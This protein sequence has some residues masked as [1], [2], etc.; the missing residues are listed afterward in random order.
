[1]QPLRKTIRRSGKAVV[2]LILA[3]LLFVIAGCSHFHAA[4]APG[5]RHPARWLPP[6]TLMLLQ[7]GDAEDLREQWGQTPVAR[8]WK[9]PVAAYWVETS[10]LPALQKLYDK[11]GFGNLHAWL[12][13][14]SGSM[15][16]AVEGRRDDRIRTDAFLDQAGLAFYLAAD[17]GNKAPE[18]RQWMD[19]HWNKDADAR[20]GVEG[21]LQAA[22]RYVLVPGELDLWAVWVETRCYMTTSRKVLVESFSRLARPGNDLASLPAWQTLQEKQNKAD[23]LLFLHAEAILTHL[24]EMES[25]KSLVPFEVRKHWDAALHVLEMLGPGQTRG[26]TLA[27]DIRKDGF[28]SRFQSLLQPDARGLFVPPE[29][30]EPLETP[31]WATKDLA[32]FSAGR[33]RPPIELKRDLWAVLSRVNPAYGNTADILYNLL[34]EKTGMDFDAILSSLGDEIAFLTWQSASQPRMAILWEARRTDVL[35]REMDRGWKA[36]NGQVE[37]G[38][39]AGYPYRNYSLEGMPFHL[40]VAEVNGFLVFSTELDWFQ[41]FLRLKSELAESQE[42]PDPRLPMGEQSLLPLLEEPF[43]PL[44]KDALLLGH[45]YSDTSEGIKQLSKSLP[46]LI[47]VVNMQLQT[48]GRGSVPAWVY[49]AL[50]PLGPFAREVFPTVSRSSR[51]GDLLIAEYWSALEP[52]ASPFSAALL[53]LCGHGFGAAK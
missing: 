52:W 29:S 49:Q 27:F 22:E 19:A 7:V 33:L 37:V 44:P 28:F 21:P 50:P 1:M 48:R 10:L 23:G 47:P 8:A 38:S 15:V 40:M 34:A 13:M 35:R 43:R 11:A 39:Y 24:R 5:L 30:G 2:L 17:F 32:S 25:L 53:V 45:Y 46:M 9:D 12:D 41:D 4:P 18:A 31:R 3:S 6:S 36:L 14:I 42:A 26:M 51:Q 20:V 16:F